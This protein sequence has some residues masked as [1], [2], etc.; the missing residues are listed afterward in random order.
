MSNR[1]TS[2]EWIEP[3]VGDARPI[4]NEFSKE[5]AIEVASAVLKSVDSRCTETPWTT[6][7]PS[8]DRSQ[9]ASRL[10]GVLRASDYNTPAYNP[11]THLAVEELRNLL[12][13]HDAVGMLGAHAAYHFVQAA[14]GKENEIFTTYQ[15]LSRRWPQYA[16]SW[17]KNL[18]VQFG[19]EGYQEIMATNA[20]LSSLQ[21]KIEKVAELHYQSNGTIAQPGESTPD[22][23]NRTLEFFDISTVDGLDEA[24]RILE[25][26]FDGYRTL[27]YHIRGL[28]APTA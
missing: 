15:D 1:Y 25:H 20:T 27:A 12:E 18:R 6:I 16:S 9:I 3:I 23:I 2:N 5:V 26:S 7:F 14:A 8:D 19:S 10:L 4:L 24:T 22:L 11:D 21:E 28:A 13:K 17:T